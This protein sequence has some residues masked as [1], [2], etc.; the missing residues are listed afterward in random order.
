MPSNSGPHS[1][2]KVITPI[3]QT[4]AD[5]SKLNARWHLAQMNGGDRRLKLEDVVRGSRY[6]SA[7]FTCL[8]D[9]IKNEEFKMFYSHKEESQP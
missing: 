8:E 3:V 2:A 7:G 4:S 5:Y 9:P 1:V 6:A